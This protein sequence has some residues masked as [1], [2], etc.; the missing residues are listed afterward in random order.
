MKDNIIRI[1]ID[2]SRGWVARLEP[3]KEHPGVWSEVRRYEG[4]G[5][6]R[7]QVGRLNAPDT[8]EV[9]I[10]EGRYEFQARGST[11]LARYLGP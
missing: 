5:T 3:L 8:S 6:A 1:G 2:P 11:V 7:T 9:R 4:R 10:P